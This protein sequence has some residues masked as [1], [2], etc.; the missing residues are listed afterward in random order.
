MTIR[1]ILRLAL[2]VSLAVALG[3]LPYRAYGPSG[4]G[5]VLQLRQ[6]LRQITAE[7]ERLASD[8]AA[9]IGRIRALKGDQRAIERVARDELGL[10]RENDIVFQFE[11]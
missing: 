7:N 2:S 9:L 10:V 3:Y 5:R 8:N 1:W 11:Q 4:V 6:Q